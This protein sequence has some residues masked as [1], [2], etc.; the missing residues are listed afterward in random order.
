MGYI[1]SERFDQYI[2][3][4]TTAQLP[5][6][7]ELDRETHWEYTLPQMLSG[8]VQGRF[9][10]MMTHMI[11]PDRVL[12]IGTFTGY[13]AICM[14]MGLNKGGKLITIDI[15]E[16]L[17]TRI[18]KFVN[19]SPFASQ[20]H[21]HVGNALDIV[22]TLDLKFNLVFIDADKD[23]YSAYYDMLIDRLESGA[24]IIADNV[25]WSGKVLQPDQVAKDKDTKALA[26]FNAQIHA[27][28]RVENVLMPIRDGL[29][30]IRKK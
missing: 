5:V 21:L 1:L 19:K 23:N 14:A 22:P 3:E 15:N 7:T 11:R 10:N 16:E 13:S 28:N 9:L 2:E 20:I 27:D 26:A 17:E 29:M 30:V 24:I 12:E 6:L 25:L 4:H 18:K 8:S